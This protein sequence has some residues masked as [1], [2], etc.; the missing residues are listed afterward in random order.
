MVES[1]E[2]TT[3]TE[4]R[5]L[6]LGCKALV[7]GM[8]V[9]TVGLGVGAGVVTS[10]HRRRR[11]ETT[12]VLSRM[13]VD[14]R[15]GGVL[16]PPPPSFGTDGQGSLRTRARRELGNWENS[17]VQRGE[18]YEATRKQVCE[19]LVFYFGEPLGPP[20]RDAWG[21]PIYYRCPGPIHKN[22]FDL[23]SCGPNGVYEEGNGDDIVVGE[24]VPGGGAA[25]SS[26]SG[27]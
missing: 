10:P 15:A 9:L 24:E 20:I 21:N 18:V 11:G 4:P 27:R 8:V 19:R 23:I 14:L 22:G 12:E 3:V 25:I 5:K 6:G 2:Q 1:A 13:A 17:I 16:S 26:E 7:A